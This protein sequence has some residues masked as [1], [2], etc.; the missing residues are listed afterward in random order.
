MALTQNTTRTAVS[1][2]EVSLPVLESAVIYKGS[3]VGVTAAGYAR[4]LVGG[5]TFKGFA[6]A[7]ADNL[8][9]ASG[10]S[11]VDVRQEGMFRLAIAGADVSANAGAPVYATDDNTFTLTPGG[12]YIGDV[13]V[14]S[15]GN[16]AIV[17]LRTGDF[18]PDANTL[19]GSVTV[20]ADA[21]AIPTAAA[22]VAK[23][24]GADAEAC[25]LANGVPG[26]VLTI[27]LVSDGGGTV[28]ITPTTASFTSVA[29]AD[30]GDTVTVQFVD[31]VTGWVP[32][33]AAGVAAPPA[34][35]A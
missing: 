3:A 11:D 9:G 6:V 1:G 24:S 29:L 13:V 26:Q 20:A 15:Q 17:A 22:F 23:S 18:G 7:G 10:D 25:T 34:F 30:A 5:D 27:A 2:D 16:E 28:T 14:W 35:T 33:G 32:L 12:S 21:L 8:A 19:Q 4:A 31:P